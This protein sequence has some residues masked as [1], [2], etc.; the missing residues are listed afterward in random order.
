MRI[1]KLAAG[2][3]RRDCEVLR[4]APLDQLLP[5]NIFQRRACLLGCNATEA[6]CV[7]ATADP[8]AA[9]ACHM[10]CDECR[11]GCFDRY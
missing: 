3:D 4:M 8:I 9:I 5:Q 10:V 7:L 6:A 11:T 2:T 1:P